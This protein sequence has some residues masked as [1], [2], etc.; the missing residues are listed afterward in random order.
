MFLGDRRFLSDLGRRLSHGGFKVCSG[1]LE[2]RHRVRHHRSEDFL[3]SRN[4]TFFD[5]AYRR[6]CSIYVTS[7]A[8]SRTRLRDES[9]WVV[10]ALLPF[11]SSKSKM[12]VRLT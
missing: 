3:H 8:P 5:A 11:R 1:I 6:V 10:I 4:E 7:S 9:A 2:R 12:N